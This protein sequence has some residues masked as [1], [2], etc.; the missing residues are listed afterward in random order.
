MVMCHRS[1]L[2]TYISVP[3]KKKKKVCNSSKLA[4]SQGTG[5]GSSNLGV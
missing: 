5:L 2:F 4:E 1:G 3:G